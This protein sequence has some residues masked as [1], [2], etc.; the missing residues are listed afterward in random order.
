MTQPAPLSK[1]DFQRLADFRYRLRR[2]LRFSEEMAQEHGL[3][4]QQYQ[5]LLQ[6]R[7][8]PGRDW[9]TVAELA[10]RLQT[11]HHSV[12][13]LVSRCEA[14]GLVQRT[15]GRDDKRCVEVSLLPRGEQL[16]EEMA[17]AHRDEL[18]A[19]RQLGG[20]ASLEM[21]L[22]ATPDSDPAI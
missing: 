12:V 8:Y 5:V 7:G 4:P 3:T 19:L 11:Q 14:L 18:L 6:L 20:F 15:P 21:L 16:V 13:G 1:D 17:R 9:A 2:F 22:L 10:E